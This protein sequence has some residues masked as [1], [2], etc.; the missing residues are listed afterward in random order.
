MNKARAARTC[1]S[2]G[3]MQSSD[4]AST[5]R[6]GADQYDAGLERNAANFVALSPLS[7]LERS[8]R[9]Y[10]ERTALVYGALRQSWAQTY[11]RCRQLAGALAARGIGRGDTVAAMLPNVPAMFEAHFGVA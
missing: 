1:A 7:F 8:A 4:Q 6:A 9:V 11:A 3:D 10:P 2:G 5:N